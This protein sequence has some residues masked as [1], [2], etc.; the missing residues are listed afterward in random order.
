MNDVVSVTSTVDWPLSAPASQG[1]DAQQLAAA[2]D[3]AAEFMPLYSLLVVRHG[4]LVGERYFGRHN[5]H[6]AFNIKS[7]SKSVLSLLV[8]IALEQGVLLSIDQPIA[9]WLP[10]Y[11]NGQTDPRK[12]DITL[13]HLLTLSAGLGWVENAS[14][15]RRWRHSPDWAQFALDLPLVGTPGRQFNYCTPLT[16][17]LSVILTRASGMSTLDY[18]QRFLF[19]PIGAQAIRWKTDPQGYA[20]GG[21]EVC[22]TARDMARLGVLVAQ[23]GNWN[24]QQIVPAAWIDASTHPQIALRQPGF[25]QPAYTDYGYLWWLRQFR[26]MDAAVASGY[27]GQL[28][29]VI[30]ALDTVVV[31]TAD[32]D[33]PF[34]SAMS[35]S[36]Q[37]ETLVEEHVLPALHKE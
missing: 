11:F 23:R 19:S 18:A 6:S 33:T 8:G 12:Y 27:A 10:E 21:S 7:A 3:M 30:P 20:V 28:I 14:G 25:W 9:A 32:T 37:I 17:L 24:G 29:I 34:S 15:V 36:R 16:H 5:A 13:R 1:V 2:Y 31:T 22:L 35:Q 4:A 26:G